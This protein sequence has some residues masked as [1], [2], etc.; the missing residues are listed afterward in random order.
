[1]IGKNHQFN[2]QMKEGIIKETEDRHRKKLSLAVIAPF[3][4]EESGCEHFYNAITKTL[5]QLDVSYLLIFVDDGSEDNTL[6]LLDAIAEKDKHVMVLPLVRNFGHQSA[7]TAGL[8]YADADVVI[9]IDS[10]MQH[11]PSVIPCMLQ[12]YRTGTNVVFAVRKHIGKIPLMKLLTAKSY[13]FLFNSISR[14][15]AIPDA[16]DFRLMSREV[17][18]TLRN[19]REVHRYLRGM[20]SWMGYSYAVVQYD[21]PERFAGK[22]QYTFKKSLSLARDGLFSFSILP[23]RIITWTGELVT[24]GAFLYLIYILIEK[25][26]GRTIE[27]WVST[28]SVILVIGGI[29]LISLGVISQYMGMVFEQSKERPLY[30]LKVRKNQT[31]RDASKLLMKRNVKGGCRQDDE[32]KSEQ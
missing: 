25:F 29:Q 10:D 31:V 2:K 30:I 15:S 16:S 5:Q 23:L 11:P 6:E 21:Q 1:V 22:P 24:L 17:V 3:Y 12:K 28:I 18:E 20:V 32:I 14:V 9:T 8:D 4:N 13:Y 19:M 7:L 27:G 26:K